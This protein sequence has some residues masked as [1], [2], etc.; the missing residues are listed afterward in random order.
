MRKALRKSF[1]G[2]PGVVHLDVPENIMN[3]KFKARSRSSTP[4]RYRDI[5]PADAD[6]RTRSRA[7]RQS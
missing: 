7:P 6:R 4:H 1:E 5:E 2:R 3:G